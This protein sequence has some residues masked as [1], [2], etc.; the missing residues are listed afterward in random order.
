MGERES[1]M[2]VPGKGQKPLSSRIYT[3]AAA[4]WPPFGP[5]LVQGNG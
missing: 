2:E 3:P 5:S 4:D 1:E